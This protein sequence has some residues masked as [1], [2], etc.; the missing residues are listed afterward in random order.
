MNNQNIEKKQNSVNSKNLTIS[1]KLYYNNTTIEYTILR[2]R[3]KNIN[4][5]IKQDG[6]VLVSCRNGI[7][8]GYIENILIKKIN[9]IQNCQD[10]YK[11]SVIWFENSE[12]ESGS[13]F[14][15]LGKFFKIQFIYAQNE[16]FSAFFDDNFLYIKRENQRGIKNKFTEWYHNKIQEIFTDI[17]N[18]SLKEF[19]KY[20]VKKPSL[21]IKNMNSRWGTCNKTKGKITLNKHLIKAPPELIE[22]V[23]VHECCHLIHNNHSRNFYSL[24]N[25]QMPDWKKRKMLLNKF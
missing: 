8:Q 18:N 5:R 19:E 1:Q 15:F 3:V 9:W 4:I 16:K 20:N 13:D 11:K 2:K 25:E 6:E 14:L 12:I 23:C 21:I 10:R 24:L 7:K 17:L 22:Y